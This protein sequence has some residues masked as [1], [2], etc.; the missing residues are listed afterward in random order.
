M[1]QPATATVNVGFEK[2][3]ALADWL[4][5]TQATTTR[6]QLTVYQGQHSVS[7]VFA[8]TL[9]RRSP[10]CRAFRIITIGS[11]VVRRE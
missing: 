8:P 4:Q 6:G 7:G 2:G 5:L 11:M 3:M 9:I 10:F 1:P